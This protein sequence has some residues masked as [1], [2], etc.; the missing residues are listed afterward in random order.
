[1]A[2]IDNLREAL[3]TTKECPF[4][5]DVVT[6]L[7][8][9]LSQISKTKEEEAITRAVLIALDT[10]I[11][12]EDRYDP[13][14]PTWQGVNERK[15]LPHD[16]DEKSG[17]YLAYIASQITDPEISARLFDA[18]WLVV[19][20]VEYARRAVLA[21]LDAASQSVIHG[22]PQEVLVRLQRAYQFAWILRSPL[23]RAA[24]NVDIRRIISTDMVASSVW[25]SEFLEAYIEHN[26]VDD[27]E[28]IRTFVEEHAQT[29]THS[30][31]F[32]LARSYLA[33]LEKYHKKQKDEK[34]LRATRARVAETFELEADSFTGWSDTLLAAMSLEK[35][36]KLYRNNG[37][38]RDADRVYSHL[39]KK[40]REAVEKFYK[41]ETASLDV[42][43]LVKSARDHVSTCDK[44]TT[45]LRFATLTKVLNVKREVSTAK[46]LISQY[47]LQNLFGKLHTATDG[48]IV[49]RTSGYGFV[50]DNSDADAAVTEKL[51]E[52][53][54]LHVNLVGETE[55]MP[56]LYQMQF[57]HCYRQN[58]FLRIVKN[59][60][61][62]PEGKE[63]LV[64]KGLLYGY[65][66]QMSEALSLLIPAYE[67][68][69]R[70]VLELND[71]ETT[72]MGKNDIQETMPFG[73]MVYRHD[74]VI[75]R[76]FTEDIAFM[77]K[78]LF[79]DRRGVNFRS[80][81]AHGELSYKDFFAPAAFYIFWFI[82]FVFINPVFR[83]LQYSE[84]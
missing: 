71:F 18:S 6:Q 20:R 30:G 10:Y 52:I 9:T 19:R 53:G 49:H 45:L 33:A 81:L 31:D 13:L 36:Y 14:K 25:I 60:P 83:S 2:Y 80:A 22:F 68:G 39:R 51:F 23:F 3:S 65:N 44:H 63:A 29:S 43:Q 70:N 54:R 69:I 50:P 41:V 21:Y 46:N 12:P 26:G 64:A 37:R 55:V 40:Q 48:R 66:F 4:A 73:T 72:T 57:E 16:L 38:K 58:D 76:L 15:Y 42:T 35:A 1:M 47:P 75:K 78:L 11:D 59:N 77:N 74:D 61:M 82:Y 8:S 79:V 7:Q 28:W 27:S 84:D 24:V 17:E 62:I 34:E 56:A 32:I 5:Q 67:S